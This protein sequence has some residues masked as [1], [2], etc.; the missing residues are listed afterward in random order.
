MRY[1][2]TVSADLFARATCQPAHFGPM[3]IE[4]I[5]V[6]QTIKGAQPIHAA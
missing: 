1:R 5:K 6:M 2:P 3:A 4:D